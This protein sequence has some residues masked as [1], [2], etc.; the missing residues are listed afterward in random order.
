MASFNPHSNP[1][2]EASLT[3]FTLHMRLRLRKEKPRGWGCRTAAAFTAPRPLG[4]W[5]ECRTLA[6]RSPEYSLLLE[7]SGAF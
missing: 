7:G 4:L 6:T 3:L 2:P 5:A 1:R